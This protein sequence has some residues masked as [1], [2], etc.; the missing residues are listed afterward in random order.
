MLSPE[1]PLRVAAAGWQRERTRSLEG[2]HPRV[3]EGKVRY[4]RRISGV[5]CIVQPISTRQHCSRV[6]QTVFRHAHTTSAAFCY[7]AI[8]RGN[9]DVNAV[10]IRKEGKRLPARIEGKG[11]HPSV[12]AGGDRERERERVVPGGLLP[13][14]TTAP[15]Y[16]L[17]YESLVF[18]NSLPSLQGRPPPV[19]K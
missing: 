18:A 4:V 19:A 7:R 3:R 15:V 1:R 8:R 2:I 6:R 14:T 16:L 13:L 11:S 9:L 17:P 5:L 12:T 10:Q